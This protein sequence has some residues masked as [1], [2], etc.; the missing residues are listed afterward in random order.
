[1][2]I[3]TKMVVQ[4][5]VPLVLML[6]AASGICK[7]KTEQQYKNTTRQYNEDVDRHIHVLSRNGERVDAGIVD[8]TNKT[9]C[10][11]LYRINLQGEIDSLR[12][13]MAGIMDPNQQQSLQHQINILEQKKRSPGRC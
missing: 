8:S 10:V 5:G 6:F 12:T 7:I 3:M 1:M 4:T 11:S 9:L 13:Q 2:K